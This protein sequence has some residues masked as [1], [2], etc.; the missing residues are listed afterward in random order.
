[1]A[2]RTP[3]RF[4]LGDRVTFTD[5][6][7]KDRRTH[8]VTWKSAGLPQRESY[9]LNE[10]RQWDRRIRHFSEGIIVGQRFL[11]DYTYS[12]ETDYGEYGVSY[13]TYTVVSQTPGTSR[14]AWLV[15]FDL[16]RKPVLVLDENIEPA[17]S[18]GL[19]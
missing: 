3:P 6:V 5:T 13:G 12:H 10:D 2:K 11:A 7:V 14:K 8:T 16:H 18:S 1:M 19:A 4:A 17:P 15:S 9:F